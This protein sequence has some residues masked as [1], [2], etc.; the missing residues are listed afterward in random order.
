MDQG[1]KDQNSEMRDFSAADEGGD[2][3]NVNLLKQQ[4]LE[5]RENP[6]GQLNSA[7]FHL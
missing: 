4:T 6:L 5:P 3:D 7:H 1:P 2:H